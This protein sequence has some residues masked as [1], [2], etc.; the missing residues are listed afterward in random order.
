M[1]IWYRIGRCVLR[2]L[3]TDTVTVITLVPLDEWLWDTFSFETS[4]IGGYQVVIIPGVQWSDERNR[5][6]ADGKVSIE[7]N[8]T[9]TFPKEVY[10]HVNFERIDEETS[11]FFGRMEEEISDVKGH[12]LSDLLK[13]YPKSGIVK[14]VK[15]NTNRYMLP[16]VKVVL[17]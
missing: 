15:D 7:S 11:V 16:N 4:E 3:F 12:R 1:V 2:A 14:M 9:I 10:K 5:T 17:D 8:A 6:N 13:R